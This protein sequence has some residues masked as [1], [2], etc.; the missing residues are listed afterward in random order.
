MEQR[1]GE[2]LGDNAEVTIVTK[3]GTDLASKPTRKRFDPTYLEQAMQRSQE[4]LRRNTLDVGL[5]HNP[6]VAALRDGEGCGVLRQWVS[7]GKL[8][9]W[10]VSAG[11]P[12]VVRAALQLA[13]PPAVI[14]LAF[15]VFMS[16]DLQSVATELKEAGVGVLARSV[17]AHGLL[18]GM[19]PV[20]KT[21]AP[22]DHRS[23][24]WTSDQLRRR[25]HQSRALR[26]LQGPAMPSMRAAAVAFVLEQELVSSAVLGVR[27]TVQLDQL[28]RETPRQAP[29]FDSRAKQVLEG[30]LV[31]LGISSEKP[32][33]A[34]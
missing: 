12:D 21:F 14:E 7:D 19:W 6:S 23:Q 33:V 24:R 2:R 18:A 32:A 15:N 10:G 16:D 31:R 8:R 17:L 27:D 4:R 13:E 25:I 28:L 9:A 3:W 30:Q 1:L 11:D 20:D 29:Y 22:E 34:P 5:L 26:A